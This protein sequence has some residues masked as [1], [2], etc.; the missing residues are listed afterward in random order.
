M[1]GVVPQDSDDATVR[2]APAF[3]VLVRG[4]LHDFQGAREAAARSRTVRSLGV[5]YDEIMTGGALSW[6]ACVEG[7]LREAGGLADRALATATELALEDHSSL[8]EPLRTRGRLSFERGDL[9]R[10]EDDLER[11]MMMVERSSPAHAL[12]SA[13]SLA[14]VWLSTGRV[15]DATELSTGARSF[16]TPGVDSPLPAVLDGLDARIALLEGDSDRAR[17]ITRSLPISPRRCRLEARLDL[18]AHDPARRWPRWN[19]VIQGRPA[20]GST[21]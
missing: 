3:D 12:V 21:S 16:L 8:S 13:A 11:S 5:V 20:S 18:A 1:E 4:W 9:H 17:A 19:A 15:K 14:R 10:A 2:A 7:S 6:V